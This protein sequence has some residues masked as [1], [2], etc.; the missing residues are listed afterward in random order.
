MGQKLCSNRSHCM[1]PAL[2]HDVRHGCNFET[3][4]MSP[5]HIPDLCMLP[6]TNLSSEARKRHMCHVHDSTLAVLHTQPRCT[7]R[8]GVRV[9]PFRR[10]KKLTWTTTLF[11]EHGRNENPPLRSS[12]KSVRP[13]SRRA[14]TDRSRQST[15]FGGTTGP[16]SKS[17]QRWRFFL[18]QVYYDAPAFSQTKYVPCSASRLE[19]AH[20]SIDPFLYVT[21]V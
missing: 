9:L 10:E 1:P 12:T 19:P 3:T 7:M 8:I 13:K 6:L 2:P 17:Q 18:K 4:T 15:K 14:V 5:S 21:Y 11:R 20:A 16:H